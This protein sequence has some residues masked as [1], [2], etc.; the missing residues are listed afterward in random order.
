MPLSRNVDADGKDI[1][2]E[3]CGGGGFPDTTVAP[4]VLTALFGHDGSDMK[5]INAHFCGC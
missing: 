2:T 4:I 3:D 1:E 5:R